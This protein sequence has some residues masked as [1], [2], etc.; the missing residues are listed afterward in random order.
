MIV[1]TNGP[2][3]SGLVKSERMNECYLYLESIVPGRPQLPDPT[4]HVSPRARIVRDTPVRNW[5]ARVLGTA[6]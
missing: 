1:A 4:Q 2:C 6:K 5:R 3:V